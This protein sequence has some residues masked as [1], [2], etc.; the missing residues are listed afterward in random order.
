MVKGSL[1]RKR[2]QITS[3]V[4]TVLNVLTYVV[5]IF[6]YLQSTAQIFFSAVLGLTLACVV[7]L[8][9]HISAV[10]PRLT[11]QTSPQTEQALFCD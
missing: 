9:G 1:R 6:P 4:L 8:A 5:C 2:A 11:R 7:V 10:V 3:W